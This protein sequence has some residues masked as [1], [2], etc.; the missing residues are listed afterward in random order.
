MLQPSRTAALTSMAFA[1][2]P[3]AHAEETAAT[4][5]PRQPIRESVDWVVERL[6][7]ERKDPCL[8]AVEQ[9]KPC[10][11]VTVEIE[12]PQVSVRESLG[13]L[14]PPGQPSPHRPPTREE[15]GPYRRRPIGPAM[16]FIALDPGC[17][18]KSALKRLRGK[19][20]VYYLYRARDVHGERAALYDR[21]V[22]PATFQGDLE[23]LGRFGSEC[24]ALAAY[25]REERRPPGR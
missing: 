5:L 22:D 9:G 13:L 14:G 25:R 18:G 24:A 12:G 10:F 17:V 20:D 11:P 2:A 19:N 8:K 7:R 23:F 4:A 15:M 1:L 21:R 3:L 6:E 16:A